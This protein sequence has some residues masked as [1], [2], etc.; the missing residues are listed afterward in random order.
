MIRRPPRSTR[1]DTLFPYTTLVRSALDAVDPLNVEERAQAV[2]ALH[3]IEQIAIARTAG[4]PFVKFGVYRIMFDRHRVAPAQLA[5]GQ[6]LVAAAIEP[7]H[8]EREARLEQARRFDDAAKRIAV[9]P[10]VGRIDELREG[11]A[12]P[13]LALDPPQVGER[14]PGPTRGRHTRKRAVQ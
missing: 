9:G 11:P 3:R 7:V 8:I 13:R 6:M 1:T 12:V 10:R 5:K 14:A 4:E 2:L